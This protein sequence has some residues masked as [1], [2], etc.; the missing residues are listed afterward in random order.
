VYEKFSNDLEVKLGEKDVTAVH[1]ASLKTKQLQI[2]SGAVYT[3][4]G[5]GDYALVDTQRYDLAAEVL[6]QYDHAIFFFNWHHQRIEM[7]KR[8][9]KMKVPFGI[10][11]STV[12]QHRRDDLVAAFQAGAIKYLGLHPK[13]GAHGLTLTTGQAAVVISPLYEADLLKQMIHRIYRGAQDKVTNTILIEARD[14]VE[15]GVY[16]RLDDKTARMGNYLE[17]AA[18]ST[19]RR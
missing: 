2:A 16:A 7:V 17:L 10:I 4:A 14:T 11:D 19:R 3:G 5:D 18:G 9:E 6:E 15:A 13:T 12:P 8:L 1:A